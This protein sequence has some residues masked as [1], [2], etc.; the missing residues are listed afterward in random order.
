MI[1]VIAAHY[2]PGWA[3]LLIIAGEIAGIRY[4][5]PK[6]IKYGI[7]RIVD[8]MIT[9]RSQVLR[10]AGVHVHRVELTSVPDGDGERRLIEHGQSIESS[11]GEATLVGAIPADERYVLVDFTLTPRHGAGDG[12]KSYYDPLDLLLVPFD[13]ASSGS[14]AN[15]DDDAISAH[16]QRVV[17][18]L[19]TGV[20]VE[21]RELSGKAR[22]RATFA[23]PPTLSGRVKFRYHSEAFGDFLLPT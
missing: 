19:K 4:L 10:G 7:G 20:E 11:T 22:L 14:I 15:A 9:V 21:V 16:V 13:S 8:S 6:L 2:V 23:L 1:P 5:I 17:Q 12:R 18:L 3:V